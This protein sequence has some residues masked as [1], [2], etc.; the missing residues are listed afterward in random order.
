MAAEKSQ[1]AARIPG[2]PDTASLGHVEVGLD[3]S[4]RRNDRLQRP[5]AAPPGFHVEVSDS[6]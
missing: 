5:G 1:P 2:F 4:G 3:G 6:P